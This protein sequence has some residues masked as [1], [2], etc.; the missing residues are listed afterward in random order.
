MT[1]SVVIITR[2]RPQMLRRCL[3]SVLSLDTRPIEVLVM[4]SSEDA[5]T[6]TLVKNRFSAVQ[7]H[8]VWRS[9]HILSTARNLGVARSTG[10][11]IGFLDDDATVHTN[12][13]SAC[14]DGYRAP[15]VGAV[16]GRV[17]DPEVDHLD[18]HR[19]APISLVTPM[20]GLT[21]NLDC[22]SGHPV[23]VHHLRGCNLSVRRDV[24]EKAGGFDE[25]APIYRFEELDLCLRIRRAGYKVMFQPGMCVYHHLAPAVG[26]ETSDTRWQTR[27]R[28]CRALMFIYARSLGLRPGTIGWRYLWRGDTGLRG[29]GRRP[30]NKALR[31]VLSGYWGKLEGLRSFVHKRSDR[32]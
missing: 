11:V 24:F 20:G 18:H 13:V 27:R 2:H 25:Q 16:G 15:N 26:H 5:D 1:V 14:L 8:R 12:W 6:E 3:E 4:D 19:A 29:L 32:Q 23:E 10:Q 31:Y 30:S 22:D 9:D 7:Y 17:L 28:N 21:D